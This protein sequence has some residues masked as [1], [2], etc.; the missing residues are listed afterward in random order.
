MMSTARNH[1]GWMRNKESRGPG[2]KNCFSVSSSNQE[3]FLSHHKVVGSTP[4]PQRC[5][6]KLPSPACTL[7]GCKALLCGTRVGPFMMS[8]T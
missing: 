8:Q 2:D 1:M 6:K 4:E 7:K 3:G 5:P